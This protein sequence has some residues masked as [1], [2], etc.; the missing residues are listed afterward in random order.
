MLVCLMRWPT[1]A[2]SQLSTCS[3]T[4]DRIGALFCGV[5]FIIVDIITLHMC[6]SRAI[7]FE[8]SFF[9]CV[10]YNSVAALLL[11]ELLPANLRSVGVGLISNAE[12]V[13]SLTQTVATPQ[14]Q[15]SIG[16]AGLFFVFASVVAAAAL[17]AVAFMPETAGLTLEEIEQKWSADRGPDD[18]GDSIMRNPHE[19]LLRLSNRLAS[20]GVE[21]TRSLSRRW[22]TVRLRRS[23][24]LN[25]K[26]A[27]RRATISVTNP[28][29]SRKGKHALFYYK[30]VNASRWHSCSSL[31]V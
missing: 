4:R 22:S 5:L 14:L 15:A 19:E 16:R 27:I 10:S 23:D 26:T 11:G 18:E 30:G 20:P 25:E 29:K 28:W 17:F 13:S 2:I 12:V 31:L 7:W 1:L 21:L 8:A 24:S 3:H 9:L 6:Y